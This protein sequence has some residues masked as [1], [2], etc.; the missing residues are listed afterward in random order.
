MSKLIRM[1]DETYSILDSLTQ[2]TG[3]SRQNIIDTALKN[4]ERDNLLKRAN[5]AYA[6]MKQ[7]KEQWQEE[8]EERALW[9]STL[10]DGLEDE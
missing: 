8:Q 7:N 3:F 1:S 9:E 2:S 10:A 5:E 6:A 4:F